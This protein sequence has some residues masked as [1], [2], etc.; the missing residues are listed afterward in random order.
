MGALTVVKILPFHYYGETIFH[1]MKIPPFHYI[2]DILCAINSLVFKYR[3][4]CISSSSLFPF[5]LSILLISLFG[6]PSP[7]PYVVSLPF[8]F[9]HFVLFTFSPISPQYHQEELNLLCCI[10]ISQSLSSAI[11]PN[12]EVSCLFILYHLIV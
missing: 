7:F 10:S 4:S 12:T 9:L 6:S 2:N 3:S 1:V 11:T 5:G 8:S